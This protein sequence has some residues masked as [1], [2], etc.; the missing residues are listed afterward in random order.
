MKERIVVGITGASG[1]IYAKKLLEKLLPLPYEIHLVI[2]DM[3]EKVLAHELSTIPEEF[4]SA[5]S[6]IDPSNEIIVHD[7]SN[8]FAPVASGSF[9][10][11]AMVVIPCSMKT[12]ASI[13]TGYTS[14]LLERASDVCLKEQ[15]PLILVTRESPLSRVHL[16]NMLKAHEAGATIM[17]ASPGFYHHPLTI[18]D[19]IE[20]VIARVLDHLGI[21]DH[22]A[23]RWEGK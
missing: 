10:V 8:M 15:R 16:E 2:S 3:G 19:L 6:E 14:N 1:S 5:I 22:D 17:P 21:K 9:P 4:I 18:D 20:S 11:K 23:A 7:S 13:A 12:L